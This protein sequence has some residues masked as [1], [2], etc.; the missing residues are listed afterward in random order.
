M[1][2]KAIEKTMSTHR[3]ENLN[4]G[5]KDMGLFTRNMKP[6]IFRNGNE[7]ILNRI[8]GNNPFPTMGT[9]KRWFL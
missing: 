4:E 5:G 6:Y 7:G 3:Q 8:M 1:S 2:A 9:I